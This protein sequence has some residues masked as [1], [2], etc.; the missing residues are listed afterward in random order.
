ML[1]SFQWA[2]SIS[3]KIYTTTFDLSRLKDKI[4]EWTKIAFNSL[5]ITKT[6]S[7]AIAP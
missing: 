4:S 6:M 2:K 5:T 1:N 3:G 7:H